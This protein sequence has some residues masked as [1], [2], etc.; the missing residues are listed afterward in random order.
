MALITETDLR[1]MLPKGIAAPFRIA[2]GDL[3]TP[4]A[5]DFL[6]SRGIPVVV[7]SGEED[8][9]P[10]PPAIPVGVSNR[11]I[12]LSPEDVERLFGPGYRLTPMRELS[13]KGQ[14]AAEE[15]VT[16]EGPKGSIRGVR[17]L[18]PARGRTQVEI[19]RTD[20]FALGVHPPVR[21][22]GRLDGTPGITVT[23]PRGAVAL[24]SGVIIAKNH[25]HMSPDDAAAFQV[26]DGDTIMLQADGVRPVIFADVAVRVSPNFSLD[27]H[28]DLD[29]ANAACLKTGDKVRLVG[30]N[31]VM[32]RGTEG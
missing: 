21:L 28:I 8:Y 29:E 26:R 23:G 9:P 22:S 27:F 19:S 1:A 11:H 18:G 13:Q 3:L 6:K 12:H 4:A 30:V 31:G 14:F 32:R 17:V 24:D 25:V 7:V 15:T 5:K 10:A 20:G 16:L 2:P